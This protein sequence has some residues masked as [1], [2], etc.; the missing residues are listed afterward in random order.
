MKDHQNSD[1]GYSKSILDA[2][3][4]PIFIVDD[5]LRILDSN[6]AGMNYLPWK[7]GLVIKNRCGDLFR[8]SHARE[9][10]GGCGQSK[11]CQYCVIRNAVKESFYGKVVI[12]KKTKMEVILK[13]KDKQ[14][15]VMVTTAPLN[16]RGKRL[17]ILSLE[18][19]S[20]LTERKAVEK[21]LR[22]SKND[23][24]LKSKSLEEVNT[25][26]NV[27][28]KK[29]DEDKSKIQNELIS[30]LKNLAFPYLEKLKN[31]GLGDVQKSYVNIL[32]SNL[33]EAVSPFYS[34]LA[35]KY[36]D[37]TPK[38]I[39]IADL[40]KQGRT[41]K[42]IA[43]LLQSSQRAIEFHRHNLRKKFG[44]L[45]MKTNLRNYLINQK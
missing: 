30:N 15:Y 12:R 14:I 7:P 43:K 37:L 29:R 1:I 22:K 24:E 27:L 33:K 39:Q 31:S 13:N 34:N 44:I 45:R 40:I 23:L 32:E 17:V 25:A 4:T 38:E 5:D 10:E 16:Y 9:N 21:R 36:S 20:E 26:L 3:P 41:T 42:E 11:E 19:I 18:D 35:L 6:V 8:C 28:L 2:I